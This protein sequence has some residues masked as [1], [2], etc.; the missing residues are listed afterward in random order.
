MDIKISNDCDDVCDDFKLVK[1]QSIKGAILHFLTLEQKT[2][3]AN[4]RFS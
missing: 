4:L 3:K 2:I 1:Q